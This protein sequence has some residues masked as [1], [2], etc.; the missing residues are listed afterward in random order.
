MSAATFIVSESAS[1]RSRSTD[2][3][4]PGVYL[5]LR[6]L[7]ASRLKQEHPGHMLQTSDLVHEVYLRLAACD[8]ESGNWL[9]RAHFFAAASEAMRRIVIDHCRRKKRLK[10]GGQMH[11]SRISLDR[12]AMTTTTVDLLALNEALDA[13]ASVDPRKALLVKLRYFAGLSMPEVARVLE[14]S[15]PTAERSW[16]YSRAW[17]ANRLQHPN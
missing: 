5:E 15:L 10:R 7:A 2:D 16:R 17:L 12:I 13:L 11:R 3:W 6:Q 9:N 14:V 1:V 8:G 4:L